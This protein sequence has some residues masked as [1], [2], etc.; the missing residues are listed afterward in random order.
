M[1]GIESLISWMI[2]CND[3]NFDWKYMVPLSIS[4]TL[5]VRQATKAI[6]ASFLNMFSFISVIVI[7]YL[8]VS[9]FSQSEVSV[10][11]ISLLVIII[12]QKSEVTAGSATSSHHFLPPSLGFSCLLTDLHRLS[13]MELKL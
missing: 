4:L 10:P 12:N 1:Y 6:I 9:I 13:T 8:H 5:T 3:E 7:I 11:Y 2:T